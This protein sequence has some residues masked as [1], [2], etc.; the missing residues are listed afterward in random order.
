M[1]AKVRNIVIRIG[2]TSRSVDRGVKRTQKLFARLQVQAKA[3]NRD[4]DKLGGTFSRLGSVTSGLQSGLSRLTKGAKLATLGI[5]G[6]AVAAASL[7]SAVSVVAG[8]GA[9]LA[10][11]AGLLT[12]VPAAAAGAAIAFGTLKLATIGVGDALKA[13]A[14]GDAEKFNEALK[15]L[16]PAARSVAR[17][18]KAVF[19]VLQQIQ[20]TAQQAFFDPLR[21]QITAVVRV[22]RGP[23][24]EGVRLVAAEW[25]M[26]AREVAIFARSAL[27]V[28]ATQ[29]L[30]G[31]TAFAISQIRVAIQPVLA[32]F[33]ALAVAAAPAL[34]QIAV[35]AGEVGAR[36]GMWLQQL[37]ASGQ[38]VPM[39]NAA[40][41][42]LK[43]LGTL[44]ANVGGIIA[45][46]FRAAGQAGG[47][48][49]GTLGAL[50]GQLNTFLKSAAGQQ[51]LTSFFQALAM[52]GASLAP[53]LTALITQVG[54]LAPAIGRLA[55]MIGPILTA[56]IN[57]VG[58]ALA[59]L[60]PGLM[61]LFGAL[62]QA[63]NA[64]APALV[65]LAQ[66]IAQVT[67]ALAPLLPMIATMIAQFVTGLAPA[68]GG[69]AATIGPA[70]VAL[71]AALMPAVQ[72]LIPVIAQLAGHLGQQLA[73]VIVALTPALVQ[74]AGIL[75]TLLPALTPIITLAANLAVFLAP[76]IPLILGV[77][78]AAKLWAIAMGIVNAVLLANPIVLIVAAVI[79]LV[80]GLVLAWKHCETFRDIVTGV[81][82]AIKNVV[83]GIPAFFSAAFGKIAS[84]ITEAVSLYAKLIVTFVKVITYPGRVLIGLL[85]TPFYYAFQGLQKIVTGFWSWAGPY[86]ARGVKV[87][88]NAILY[89]LRLMIAGWNVVWGAIGP[90]VTRALNAV[91]RTAAQFGG[92]LVRNFVGIANRVIG[93]FR[94]AGRWLVGAGKNI[95]IGLWNGIASLA[96]W[97][98]RSIGNLIARIIPGP[99]RR[100]LGIGSPSRVMAKLGVN[101]GEGLALG[102]LAT[103]KLVARAAGTLASAA[104]PAMP[105]PAMA[106][107][108]QP[109]PVGPAMAGGAQQGGGIDYGRMARAN[110]AAF[111][112]AG[113][114]IQVDREVLG[115]VTSSETGRRTHQ[116]RRTG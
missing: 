42:V 6:I 22:L 54:A 29:T 106:G 45:S 97:I 18:F 37:A 58:P 65:P 103:Q 110:V 113:L 85:V 7:H 100:V 80:A 68:L 112:E 74:L 67:V 21:G 96:G 36:F 8:L 115:R 39:I 35:A 62:A 102:I 33:T 32:G 28:R 12:A 44:L 75:V 88:V 43:Q 16:A 15:K 55:Q 25:G 48:F 24:R 34:R 40:L 90:T 46:V 82:N 56:A 9:S 95:I 61:A 105:T 49:L 89:P 98:A 53:V 59:A 114:T 14:A 50:T 64:V 66:A 109:S 5:G 104:V 11:L 107:A 72:P 116:A 91:A 73:R 27:A 47:D 41:G 78:A 10:P 1:A 79:A 81:F 3:M 99:V 63:V 52:I 51:A 77:V 108:A 17:E 57:A 19:P 71:F 92:W 94:N 76:V 101:T 87:V 84:I 23:L 86:V 69:M 20:R 70:L 31:S 38:V 26:A 93:V 2:V 30:F 83:M 13:A 4:V 60:E 111:R